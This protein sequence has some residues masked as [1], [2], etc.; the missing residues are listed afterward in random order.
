V[1]TFFAIRK[2]GMHWSRDDSIR[3]RVLCCV[4]KGSVHTRACQFVLTI[5]EG[6]GAQCRTYGRTS[7][8]T[9]IMDLPRSLHRRGDH[10]CSAS[11]CS[12]LSL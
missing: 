1:R 9:S 3:A 7:V 4:T 5:K 2:V 12:K 10:P 8:S 11:R 6:I